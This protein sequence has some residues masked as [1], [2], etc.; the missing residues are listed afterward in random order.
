MLLYACHYHIRVC[1]RDFQ[2]MA[3]TTFL[4]MV[5]SVMSQ[6]AFH[7]IHTIFIICMSMTETVQ[8]VF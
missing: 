2:A 8:H 4:S 7:S 3:N 1:A 6:L 5:F